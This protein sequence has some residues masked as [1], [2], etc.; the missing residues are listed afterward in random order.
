MEH[1]I[2]HG[3][4]SN[5]AEELQLNQG[6]SSKSYDLPTNDEYYAVVPSSP[7]M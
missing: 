6:M 5:A 3:R 1:N 4:N 2:I 7:R